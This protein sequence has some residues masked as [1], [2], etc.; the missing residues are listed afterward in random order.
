MNKTS[1]DGKQITVIFCF[2][3]ITQIVLSLSIISVTIHLE[4][5]PDGKSVRFRRPVP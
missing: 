4:V 1:Q 3:P 2:S 5:F